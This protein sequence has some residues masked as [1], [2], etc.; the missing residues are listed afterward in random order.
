MPPKER[1]GWRAS[2]NAPWCRRIAFTRPPAW[3]CRLRQSCGTT[4]QYA[5]SLC[6]GRLRRLIPR[7]PIFDPKRPRP[8]TTGASSIISSKSARVERDH[9]FRNFVVD[10]VL[11][12]IVG[13]TPPIPLVPA[14]EVPANSRG[15]SSLTVSD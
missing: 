13:A 4:E 7:R 2:S 15:F 8:D 14:R 9:R 6:I 1:V 11:R 10:G 3:P 12:P 5:C